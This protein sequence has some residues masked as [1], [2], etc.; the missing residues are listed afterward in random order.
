MTDYNIYIMDR[1]EKIK[2]II[3]AAA[4]LFLAGYTFFNSLPAALLLSLVSC[5]YP[6]HVSR[7]LAQKRKSELNLQFKDALY[8]LSSALGAGKSLESSLAEVLKDIRVL[9]PGE[10][11]Y[12]VREFE[13]IC[14]MMELNEPVEKILFDFAHRS[15]LEDIRDFADV[16]SICK[17]TGGNLVQVVKNTANMISDR[18]EVS[19]EIELLL[20]RQKYERKILNVMPFLFIVLIRF[21]GGGYMDLLYTTPRGYLLMAAALAIL[22]LSYVVSAKITDITV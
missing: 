22:V 16:L 10:N 15:G 2:H 14:R 18:I 5:L 1:R 8:S 6:R 9:Y 20:T 3:I 13:Y 21:G 19:Q 12:I 7:V 11:T 17:R 4:S